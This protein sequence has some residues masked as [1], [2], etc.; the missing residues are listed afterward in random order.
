MNDSNVTF[1][2][3][4]LTLDGEFNATRTWDGQ[5]RLGQLIRGVIVERIHPDTIPFKVNGSSLIPTFGIGDEGTESSPLTLE[6]G[7]NATL[8]YSGVIALQP[9]TGPAIVVTPMD[10]YNYTLRLV[11]EG[12]QTFSVTATG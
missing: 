6:P 2:I 9:D 4:G 12:M 3:L 11:G 1:R 10:G 5:Y 7:Q 8:S